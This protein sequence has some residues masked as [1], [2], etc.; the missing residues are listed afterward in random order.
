MPIWVRVAGMG[1]NDVR[2][3]VVLEPPEIVKCAHFKFPSGR[4][5]GTQTRS[6]EFDA[7]RDPV[8]PNGESKMMPRVMRYQMECC[9]W[10]ILPVGGCDTNRHPHNYTIAPHPYFGTSG[11]PGLSVRCSRRH[12]AGLPAER[13]AAGVRACARAARGQAPAAV[14]ARAGLEHVTRWEKIAVLTDREW[15]RHS[16]GIFGYLIPGEI[17]AF[18][19][20]QEDEARAW[21]A[22]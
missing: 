19:A 11:Y 8:T 18:P 4:S 2:R 17:R 20:A 3:R 7:G 10:R 6:H 13:E 5:A 9:C 22:S 21:V 1:I 15:L 14:P 16:V 12:V